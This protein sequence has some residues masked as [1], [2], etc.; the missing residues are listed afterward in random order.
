[1]SG[2]INASEHFI[3]EDF[4]QEVL[5]G[6]HEMAE[7]EQLKEELGVEGLEYVL[8]GGMATQS[9][10]MEGYSEKAKSGEFNPREISLNNILR[11]TEDVDFGFFN[12]NEQNVDTDINIF[13]NRLTDPTK[14]GFNGTFAKRGEGSY[15][16]K[17]KRG[18]NHG[19]SI[20]LNAA[21]SL[22]GASDESY[23]QMME[24]RDLYSVGDTEFYRL[25]VEDLIVSK[26]EGYLNNQ[27]RGKDREDARNLVYFQEHNIDQE[28]LQDRISEYEDSEKMQTLFNSLREEEGIHTYQ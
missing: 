14:G 6:T 21:G 4:V 17:I 26:M 23:E 3:N 28:Y 27:G 5:S 2:N 11:G 18:G 22:K 16:G 15:D 1:M 12:T 20:I 8:G 10:I 7:D 24:N 25:K 13:L 9:Y 19:D